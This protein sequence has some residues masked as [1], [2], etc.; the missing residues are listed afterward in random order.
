[1][2][3]EKGSH[4]TIEYELTVDGRTVDSSHKN[5][6]L[7]YEQ[8]RDQIIRG[9]EQ[10]LEGKEVGEELEVDISP[11]DAYGLRDEQAVQPIPRSRLPEDLSPEEGMLLQ[12]TVP[13]GQVFRALVIEVKPDAV[14]IDFNHPLAG[15]I[16]RF[17]IQ[18]LKVDSPLDA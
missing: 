6:P 11:E 14:L 13:D 8:G 9:L 4:V 17:K 15:K 12:I 10:V 7:I 18:I 5:G 16:L 2:K 1:M 3:I